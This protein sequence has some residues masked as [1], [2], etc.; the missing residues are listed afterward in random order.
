[1]IA[2][3]TPAAGAC[4]GDAGKARVHAVAGAVDGTGAGLCLGLAGVGVDA[5]AQRVELDEASGILLVV[6]VVGLEGDN[7]RVI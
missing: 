7:L 2:E 3:G 5:Q 6:H 4:R 1:M